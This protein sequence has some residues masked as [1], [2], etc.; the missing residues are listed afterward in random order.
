[1][2][3]RF[4]GEKKIK[5]A[6]TTEEKTPGGVNLIEV[7]FEDGTIELFSELM[8]KN[9]TSEE[10]CDATQ[11]REKRIV[12]IVGVLLAVL[13]DYG[14]KLGELSYMSTLL[15]QSLQFNEAEAIKELWSQWALKPKSLD[16]VD[17]ITVDRVLKSKKKTLDEVL[18][19]K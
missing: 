10:S 8:Y 11:L 6:I 14:I 3:T 15:N 9:T 13:R 12:P 2:E 5:Q 4:I 7:E 16:D 1:M 17:L 19:E 18:G